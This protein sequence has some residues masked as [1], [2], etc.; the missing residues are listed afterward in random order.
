[1]TRITRKTT[2][3]TLSL[4]LLGGCDLAPEGDDPTDLETAT[5]RSGGFHI[6]PT[7]VN[8]QAHRAMHYD[9]TAIGGGGRGAL[10]GKRLMSV[11]V[12][13][14]GVP[15]VLDDL[16]SQNG[17]LH[18]TSRGVSFSGADFVG[19]QWLHQVD[20]GG[21]WVSHPLTMT[22]FN[23][24]GSAARYELRWDD[25]GEPMCR[26]DADGNTWAV[27]LG[28]VY[29]DDDG[30]VTDRPNTLLVGCGEGA[31]AKAALWGYRPGIVGN[32]GYQA[33][34]RM[35]IADYCGDGTA[36]TAEGTGLQVMDVW[37]LH[38]T[39]YLA[40]P[41]EAGWDEN[42]ATCLL[43]PRH[44][45]AAHGLPCADDLPPC[46]ANPIADGALLWSWDDDAS[47]V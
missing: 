37:G 46:G 12:H 33:A 29:L 19:S 2:L 39:P 25:S 28:D 36:Y 27:M 43:E 16:W 24:L 14:G 32:D 38:S 7:G 47:D 3:L 4:A 45:D 10:D 44:R 35:V 21:T 42:G 34:V 40:L 22:A 31:A 41:T 8:N 20:E 26:V 6:G 30:T 23:P 5:A 15:Y 18:G 11:T 17:T 9:T 13:Q 1:M